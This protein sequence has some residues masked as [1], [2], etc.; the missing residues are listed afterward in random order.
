M[1]Q[2]SV[3]QRRTT[4]G[5][6]AYDRELY[7]QRLQRQEWVREVILNGDAR[8]LVLALDKQS[9]RCVVTSPPYWGLRDYE[10]N[11]QIGLESTPEQYV[12]ELVGLFRGIRSALA[13]DGT[14]WLNLGDSYH[15]KQLLGIPWQVAFALQTDGWFLRND[16][17]WS[18]PNPKP[19]S[20]RD[21]LTRS[22]EYVFLLS[23]TPNYYF[24]AD[25]IREPL[26]EYYAAPIRRG[27]VAAR[28]ATENFN[29][30]R[31]HKTGIKAASTREARI[32]FVNPLGK[33]KR[34][35]WHIP[36]RGFKGA[37][38]AVMPEALVEPCVLAGSA[39]GDLVLDPFCGSGTVGVV[40]RQLGRDFVGIELNADY[41]ALAERRINDLR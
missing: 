20:V 39:P 33:N 5:T 10:V 16:V 21:R 14:V 22:H 13:T 41:A 19:E 6:R 15:K 31:R 7:H 11:D 18:K 8:E 36:V 32:G 12:N 3:S 4:H 40:A 37:H 2:Q 35:V 38:F 34:S 28:P 29:K 1:H 17:V 24:N 30:E 25:A 9:V 27:V 26:S 23:K